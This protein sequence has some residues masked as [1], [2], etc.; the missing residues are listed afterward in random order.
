MR[1]IVFLLS[2]LIVVNTSN[3]QW[4]TLNLEPGGSNY[5]CW[6]LNFLN[7]TVGFAAALI[8][9]FA[10]GAIFKTIDGG[11]H[12]NKTDFPN[13]IKRSEERRVGKECRSRWSPY[14]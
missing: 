12:W 1:K 8:D 11:L 4:Q 7:D 13:A 3:A 2:F 14:H 5:I 10:A 9:E 6:N